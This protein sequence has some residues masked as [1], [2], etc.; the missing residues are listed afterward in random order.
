M[1]HKDIQILD[2]SQIRRTL[3]RLAFEILERHGQERDLILIGIQRRGVHLARRIQEILES[4]LQE[5]IPLGQLDINMYRDD[6]TTL[7]SSPRISKTE[8]PF[9]IDS[10]KVI[11][12]DDVLF[13]GRTVRAAL[14]AVLDFGRPKR[15]EL[16]VL[17]DRGHR[18]LPI[19][20]DYVG[21]VV[22]TSFKEHVDVLLQE[23]D[24][25]EEVILNCPDQSV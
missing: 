6:W 5:S 2:R 9:P 1:R 17:V 16:L 14:D 21:K 11:L 12:V 15:V 8:I 10:K 4:R 25:R 18:E 7:S 19:H 20:A 3:E 23:Q 13:T 22:N 24:G